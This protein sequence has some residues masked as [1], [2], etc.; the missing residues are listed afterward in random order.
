M[1]RII[2]SQACCYCSYS[3]F[4]NKRGQSDSGALTTSS[5]AWR[6]KAC[7]PPMSRDRFNSNVDRRVKTEATPIRRVEV[8]TGVERRRD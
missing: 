3:L 6:A 7:F 4:D 5:Q 1:G 8:I 2:N